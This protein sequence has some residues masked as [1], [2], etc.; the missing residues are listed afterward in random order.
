MCALA[1]YTYEDYMQWEGDWELIY[2]QAI[3]MAPAPIIDHQA[4]MVAISTQFYT[5]IEE[6]EEC[7]V[8]VEEDWKIADD[9]VVR[10]DVVVVCGKF[11]KYITKAPEIV[12][13]IV[14]ASTAK[15]D[16]KIK[17]K[18][19]EDEKVPY[20]ILVYPEDKRAKIYKL[21]S[22]KYEKIGDFLEKCYTFD[23]II[24]PVNLNFK[25]VFKKI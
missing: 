16:E 11:D 3:A 21:K 6:C 23:D 18:L 20:Y 22:G 19:Y 1:Y 5:Q 13:E 17:F 4:V 8:L 2:G 10:P 15:K 25:R 9:T 14:S 7:M 24:C 12:V